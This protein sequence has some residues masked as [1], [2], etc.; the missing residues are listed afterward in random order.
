[1]RRSRSTRCSIGGGGRHK[2]PPPCPGGGGHAK[3]A[4]GRSPPL[5][6]TPQQLMA[7]AYEVF[8][9]QLLGLAR[10]QPVLLIIEEIKMMSDNVALLNFT[11]TSATSEATDQ[12]LPVRQARATWV[13]VR[14]DG[15]W[16]IASLRVLPS[17]DDRVIREQGR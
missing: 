5:D 12:L 13:V 3:Q 4:G 14:E 17:E 1:M 6:L 8:N 9:D 15:D 7:R 2:P 10:R 11:A 16:L